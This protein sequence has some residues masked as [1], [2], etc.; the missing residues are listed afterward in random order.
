MRPIKRP[1]YNGRIFEEKEVQ[2]NQWEKLVVKEL[3]NQ[4]KKIHEAFQVR[5]LYL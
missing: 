4:G 3:E 2:E 5:K 1:K